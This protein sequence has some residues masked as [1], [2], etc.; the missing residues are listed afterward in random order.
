GPYSFSKFRNHCPVVKCWV[1]SGITH[2]P[3]HLGLRKSSRPFGTSSGRT[4]FVLYRIPTTASRYT[5]ESTLSGSF[6]AGGKLAFCGDRYFA[7]VPCFFN[8]CMGP[9]LVRTRSKDGF[10][11]RTPVRVRSMILLLAP[12]Q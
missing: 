3:R 12:R 11:E 10:P 2:F 9:W 7:I 6:I 4:S 8:G 1:G 5:G